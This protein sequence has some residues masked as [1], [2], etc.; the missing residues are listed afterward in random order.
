M[1]KRHCLVPNET[2][3]IEEAMDIG[4][5]GTTALQSHFLDRIFSGIFAG[6]LGKDGAQD[7]LKPGK[8][9]E[10]NILNTS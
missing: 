5:T 7:S 9:K 8:P 10:A 4:Q 6:V 1:E 2:H 3:C